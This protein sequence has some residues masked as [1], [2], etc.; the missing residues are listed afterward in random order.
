MKAAFSAVPAVALNAAR[1]RS[2]VEH[3]HAAP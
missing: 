3:Q 2:E 1:E